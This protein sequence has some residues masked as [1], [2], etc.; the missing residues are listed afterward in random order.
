MEI[1]EKRKGRPAGSKNVLPL[2]DKAETVFND[3]FKTFDEDLTKVTPRER[4][5]ACVSLAG[6]LITINQTN[7]KS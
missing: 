1:I 3:L 6:H 7:Q 5:A 2:N 4:I